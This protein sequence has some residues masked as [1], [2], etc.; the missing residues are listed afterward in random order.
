[1]LLVLVPLPCENRVVR[2]SQCSLSVT[3]VIFPLAFVSILFACEELAHPVASV[4]LP[5]A[6]V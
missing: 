2:G 6:H 3:H 1:M 5:L 4:R